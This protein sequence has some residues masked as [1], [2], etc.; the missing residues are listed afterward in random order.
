[1]SLRS[2]VLV[3]AVSGVCLLAPPVAFGQVPGGLY[4]YPG[5]SGTGFYPYYWGS[6]HSWDFYPYG[7]ADYG[8]NHYGSAPT[9]FDYRSYY[10]PN[11]YGSVPTTTDDSG[12][13]GLNNSGYIP[14]VV[15]SVAYSAPMETTRRPSSSS[16]VPVAAELTPEDNAAHLRVLV[17]PSAEL[18]FEGKRMDLTGAERAF[19]SPALTPGKG[20]VYDVRARWTEDGKQIERARKVRVRANQH[21]EVDLTQ[22]QA[23]DT[24]R[25]S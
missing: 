23:G 2:L 19:V 14:S 1:M 4:P 12:Y 10:G 22:A 3:V 6:R 8:L 11:Y 24:T 15:T 16:V 9:T 20:Y 17:P 25:G 21:S 13:Y 7:F 5:Y 18:W